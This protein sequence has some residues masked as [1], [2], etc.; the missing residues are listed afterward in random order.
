MRIQNNISAMT[1]YRNYNNINRQ[2]TVIT[3]RLSSGLRINRAADDPAG[4]AISEKMRAQIRGMRMASRNAQDAIN[5]V[6]TA[7]GSLQSTHEI[8]QRMRELAV[9]A[10]SDTNETTIDRAALDAEFQQLLK[11][12]GDTAGKAVFNDVPM[13]DGKYGATGT[14]FRGIEF[15]NRGTDQ[16]TLRIGLEKMEDGQTYTFEVNEGGTNKTVTYTHS[17]GN[18]MEDFLEIFTDAGITAS[19]TEGIVRIGGDVS[20]SVEGVAMYSRDPNTKGLTIQ[21]G[22]NQGDE[23]EIHLDALTIAGLG[24]E[25]LN[26]LD[27]E[28]ASNA[29]GVVDDAVKRVAIQ[30]AELGAVENRLNHK[31][32]N[33]ENSI[34]NLSDAESRIRDLDIAEAMMEYARLSILQQAS[35]AMMAQA[36]AQAQNVLQLLQF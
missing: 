30:R 2:L 34:L 7:E 22:A 33:L 6:R 12:I 29:I 19:E 35:I 15:L 23:M 27:R 31:I 11:E 32:N 21:T 25:G 10:A 16:S 5:L 4:L 36:N 18:T 9:Q 13:L 1:A 14:K 3:E 26:L 28:S 24:L 20:G 8:L 17:T